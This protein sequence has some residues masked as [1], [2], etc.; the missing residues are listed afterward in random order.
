MARNE[1]ELTIH[2]PLKDCGISM[3]FDR[4]T[5]VASYELTDAD[6]GGVVSLYVCGDVRID[7]EGTIYRYATEMP[8]ELRE[9]I[10]N[11]KLDEDERVYVWENNWFEVLLN[12][13]GTQYYCDEP[14]DGY[15][16]SEDALRA[17]LDECIEWEH[18]AQHE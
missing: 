9:L 16:E 10:R 5:E 12:R 11:G 3:L 8:D 15:W 18:W 17:E 6:G 7:F 14:I 1:R 4:G 2:V 13:N